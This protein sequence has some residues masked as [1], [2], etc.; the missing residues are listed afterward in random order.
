MVLPNTTSLANKNLNLIW[1]HLSNQ[2]LNSISMMWTGHFMWWPYQISAFP[3]SSFFFFDHFFQVILSTVYFA[4]LGTFALI[5][6]LLGHPLT[7]AVLYWGTMV[8]GAHSIFPFLVRE[9]IFA[10]WI[11][12]KKFCDTLIY[13]SY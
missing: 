12:L 6:S 1:H 11:L 5:L 3:T 10:S 2:E 13:E 9:Y 4:L 8:Y 7:L